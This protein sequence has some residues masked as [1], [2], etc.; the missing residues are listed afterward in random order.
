VF[1]EVVQLI[2]EIFYSEFAFEIEERMVE[3]L[4]SFGPDLVNDRNF[5][6]YLDGSTKGLS[7][8]EDWGC[9]VHCRCIWDMSE[10]RV[11]V[12]RLFDIPL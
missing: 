9:V 2:V 8:Y 6:S 5:L 7:G 11:A 10:R 3:A 4:E 12:L 1:G